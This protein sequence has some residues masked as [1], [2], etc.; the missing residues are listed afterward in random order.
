[1]QVCLRKEELAALKE[2]AERSGRTVG[3]LVREAIRQVCLR[4][5]A[6][7][8]VGLWDGKPGRTSVEHDVIYD[9]QP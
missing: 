7:G 5:D 3:E 6:D 2:A 9:R 4:P 8:P 1:M